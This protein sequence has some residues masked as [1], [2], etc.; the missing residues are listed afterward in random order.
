MA[1]VECDQ[2]RRVVKF[3]MW[4]LNYLQCTARYLASEAKRIEED[5]VR[6]AGVVKIDYRAEDLEWQH[7]YARRLNDHILVVTAAMKKFARSEFLRKYAE[8]AKELGQGPGGPDRGSA[9]HQG[10]W[11]SACGCPK[12]GI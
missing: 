5:V 7:N 10:C 3:A 1:R 4:E 8:D 2:A 6:L 11:L 9:R 12:T